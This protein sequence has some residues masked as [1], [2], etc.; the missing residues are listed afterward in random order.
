MLT[1]WGDR[2]KP[3]KKGIWRFPTETPDS[4][5]HLLFIIFEAV[6]KAISK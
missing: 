2:D 5:K 6:A 3:V 4:K 1:C